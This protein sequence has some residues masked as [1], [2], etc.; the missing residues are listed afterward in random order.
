METDG[1]ATGLFLSYKDSEILLIVS[2]TINFCVL[3]SV[4]LPKLC[5][6]VLRMSSRCQRG[7]E[8]EEQLGEIPVWCRRFS[9]NHVFCVAL[10]A[11]GIVLLTSTNILQNPFFTFGGS[12]L[13]VF[14]IAL[15]HYVFKAAEVLTF[16]SEIFHYKPLLVHH[17]VAMATYAVILIFEENTLMGVV[18]LCVE[19]SLIFAEREKER[20][21]Q[22]VSFEQESTSRKCVTALVFVLAI[23]IKGIIPVSIIIIAFLMALNE[24]L[25]MS[26]IPLAFFFLSLV[27]FA[28]VNLWFF[29]DAFNEVSR[30]FTRHPR[31]PV[32][33]IPIHNNQKPSPPT[34]AINNEGL[35]QLLLSKEGLGSC[36]NVREN[37]L[38][39][40]DELNSSQD[41]PAILPME[42]STP[43][44]MKGQLVLEIGSKGTY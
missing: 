4:I 7:H 44:E 16:R 21:R 5:Q 34:T 19:G 2:L 28:S 37:S 14:S 36:V 13:L 41:A 11:C 32:I 40:K 17:V 22:E 38:W 3:W 9:T 6:A 20:F 10:P 26:Y 1:F 33:I 12:F 8:M 23:I 15:G 24:L 31:F 42:S 35:K 29:R 18:M 39:G 25:R 43:E 27:F 30:Q